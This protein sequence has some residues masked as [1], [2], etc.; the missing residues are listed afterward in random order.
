[1]KNVMVDLETLGRT[2]GC[3]VFAIGAV[4]FGV[5][6][7]VADSSFYRVISVDSCIRA[8]LKVDDETMAWWSIQSDAGRDALETAMRGQVAGAVDLEVA[9]R[10]FNSWL[11][12]FGDD[13]KVWGNGASF[14]NALLQSA[15]AAVRVEPGWKFWNDRCYRTLKSLVPH[16]AFTRVGTYHNALDDARSQ[17]QHA[18]EIFCALKDVTKLVDVD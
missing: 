18:V 10:E 9:L 14:D 13:V 15:Y 11:S 5:S 3:V 4:A 7:S 12:S 1:M 16:V 6:E 8:G 17:A 2:A